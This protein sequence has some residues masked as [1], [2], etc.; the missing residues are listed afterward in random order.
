MAQRSTIGE[1]A[2]EIALQRDPTIGDRFDE[3]GL[4]RLLRDT[5]VFIERLAM[6]VAS[7]DPGVMRSFAD[8]VSPLLRRRRV[9]VDDAAKLLDGIRAASASVLAPEERESAD[10]ALDAGIAVFRDYRRIAGDARRRNPLL[11]AIYKGG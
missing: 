4:R 11:A 8:Q 7:D 10:R 3:L 1:R 2:L 9:S 6:A 5:Q